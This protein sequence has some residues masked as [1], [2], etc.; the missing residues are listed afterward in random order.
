MDWIQPIVKSWL[1]T[2][3]KAADYKRA[4]FQDD[5]EEA[6]RFF[7]G[8]HDFMYAGDYVTRH[9]GWGSDDH[10]MPSPTFRMTYNKV[11]EMV[12]LFGP[13]LYHRNPHR[14]VTPSDLPDIPMGLM[15]DPQQ[16]PQAAQAIQ[17]FQQQDQQFLGRNQL[18]SSLMQHYLNYT[19]NELDLRGH[20]R[21]AI[22]EA[23]IKGMG[24]LWPEVYTP[25]GSAPRM[26]GSFYDSVDNLVVDPDM[27]DLLHAKFIARRRVLP[28]YEVERRFGLKERELRGNLESLKRQGQA[29]NVDDDYQY[30][31]RR[32]D[33]CDLF[34][35][36]EIYSRIGF[37]QHLADYNNR[38]D[39]GPVTKKLDRFGNYIFLA[40]SEDYEYP[41][42][43]PEKVCNSG[44]E[45]DIFMRS[46]WPTPFW[47]DPTSPWPFVDITFHKRPRKVW[48]MS[49][50]KPGL[51][52]IRFLNWCFSFIADKIK[53]TSR[54][55]VAC[56]KSAGEELRTNI[57]S[58]R[59]LTLLEIETPNQRI[60][61]VVQFLQHPTFNKDVWS[62]MEA[63]MGILEKRIGLNELMYG[64]SAK[65]L[66]SA[67]E[68]QIKG[69]QLRIRP[70]DMAECVE[71]AMTLLAR[72]EA[73]AAY[74]HLEG[75]DVAPILGP[76]RSQLWDGLV[77]QQELPYIVSELNYRI[78]AGSIRKPNRNRDQENANNAV[79]QWGPLLQMYFQMTGDPQPINGLSQM[80]AKANDLEPALL[81]IKPPPP[82]QPDQ[83]EQ[84]KMQLEMQKM[85]AELQMKQAEV[86]LKAMEKQADLQMKQK[87]A[88]AD[89][90]LKQEDHQMEMF[91]DQEE[92]DQEMVQDRQTHLL[93]ML[94]TRQEGNLKLD[95]AEKQAEVQRKTMAAQ[96]KAKPSNGAP[97]KKEEA[98]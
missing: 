76:Q 11:A 56:L 90:S 83:G 91:Q 64:E 47:A 70:D 67:S 26:V 38:R 17:Q 25:P 95:L 74:W 45:Q 3:K 84:Q 42:N 52:E 58:G 18:I 55:F 27:E 44:K 61:D 71:S 22:D 39:P 72:K 40:V 73:I 50:V 29:S 82:P 88:E 77:K 92:H 54:D 36:W 1:A 57:L 62:T 87:G 35:Y 63:M 10:S 85:Q 23:I 32:G 5:A 75:S 53:N 24:L 21:Q 93:K 97:K 43:V 20:G 31:R 9:G 59:D 89:M 6:M 19:P 79:Q 66:R 98:K 78:E 15:G 14:Q 48:P 65:Q 34:V 30:Y 33:T 28:T 69:D 46:Q 68:A 41:L 49:H 16:D 4:E 94:Q 13:F 7:D 8:P 96:A 2:I 60:Q 12:Q 86:K 51:G 81:Q 37:G 80:W